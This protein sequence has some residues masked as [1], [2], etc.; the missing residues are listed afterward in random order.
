M[1][2]EILL[3]LAACQL[4]FCVAEV[5]QASSYNAALAPSLLGA[6]NPC[7]EQGAATTQDDM[8]ALAG[9]RIVSAVPQVGNVTSDRA[10]PKILWSWFATFPQSAAFSSPSADGCPD[11]VLEL[12]SPSGPFL[13]D[14]KLSYHYGSGTEG[15]P[16]G[17]SG[18]NPV[19]LDL[20]ESFLGEG[21]FAQLYANLSLEI[22]GKVSVRYSY[23][24]TDYSQECHE[25]GGES[26]CACE[27]HTSLGTREYSMS[28]S[29]SRVLLVETGPV[30]ESWLNPPL[31]KRLAG[32]GT[33]KLLVFARRMPANISASAGGRA[34]GWSSQYA[35]SD[36]IGRCGEMTV[37]ASSQSHQN[38]LSAHV[39]N[40]TLFPS[41]LVDRNASYVP[42]YVEF[43]WNESP[44]KKTLNISFEDW[45]SGQQNFTDN[46]SVREPGAFS[47]GTGSAGM[48]VRDGTDSLSPAAYP[49]PEKSAALPDYSALA[50]LLA[51]PI[52]LCAYSVLPWARES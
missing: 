25:S 37:A 26:N 44:G 8:L 50:A 41:Q 27:P 36:G 3:L 7:Q 34:I 22:S 40:S 19:P 12:Y 6:A 17:P 45:F 32:N 39:G 28:V 52:A 24:D 10:E 21:D 46:F 29:D 11:S 42:V 35:F 38:G 51:L 23:T 9:I 20:N 14:A 49:A 4:A 5:E 18:P 47:A 2:R 43:E 13:S 15:V 33:A 31:H 16:L 30:Q 1:M 48:E